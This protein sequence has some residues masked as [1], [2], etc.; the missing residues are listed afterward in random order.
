[1][2]L[3]LQLILNL[4]FHTFFGTLDFY[5]LFDPDGNPVSQEE[6]AAIYGACPVPLSEVEGP[7]P[8]AAGAPAG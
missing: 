7:A 5:P 4:G 8:V 1:M 3:G 6:S 2:E